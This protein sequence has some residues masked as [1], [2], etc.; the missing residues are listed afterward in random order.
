M[1]ST[2][3]VKEQKE[4]SEIPGFMLDIIRLSAS[5]LVLI[6]HAYSL[7]FGEIFRGDQKGNIAHE[8]VVVFFV[9]S[10]FVI[11]YSTKTRNRGK[12]Q[13]MKARLS[14]LY[15]IIFP[16]VLFTALI[17]LFITYYN[18][19]FAESLSKGM[20]SIRYF[21]SL[22]F[23][24]EIWFLSAAPLINGPLWSLSYEFWYYVLWGLWFFRDKTIKSWAL[25]VLGCLVAGPKILLMM[26]IWIF[27]ALAFLLPKI[28]LKRQ[29]GGLIV[30]LLSLLLIAVVYYVPP[31]PMILGTSPLFWGAQFFS[32]WFAGFVIASIL[33]VV[34]SS[35]IW[36]KPSPKDGYLRRIA[37]M[38]FP[39]YVFHYP[40]LLLWRAV[41]GYTDNSLFELLIV[42]TVILLICS[43]IGY[44]LES[45][46]PYWDRLF[47]RV[48]F[49]IGLK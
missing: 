40:L 5:L 6:V 38:T 22:L 4:I 8:A 24:N 11:A 12:G 49:R 36:M 17:E 27:G 43:V 32:D 26:P 7:W 29:T 10:G 39:V 37:D 44:F 2:T 46:K 47:E 41:L 45:K 3:L 15:S 1:S 42:T 25:I 19:V 23:L 9:L 13:Y 14:R 35:R 34:V 28:E 33:W 30:F 21:I 16:A 20:P 48:V 18:P 31:M